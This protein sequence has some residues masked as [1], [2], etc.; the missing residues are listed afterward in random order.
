MRQF[1]D[2][3]LSL[4]GLGDLPRDKELYPTFSPRVRNLLREETQT[5]LERS[6]FE[7]ESSWAEIL[8]AEHT[9][10]NQDLAAYYGFGDV[11]GD[12][13]QRV[14]L[15]R[16][17][18]LGLLTQGAIM[19]AT[20]HSNYTNPVARGAF[21]LKRLLCRD[22]SLPTGETL[23]QIKPPDPYSGRTGRER[24]TAHRAQP[25]CAACHD[26]MDPVG[27][28]FENYDAVG[29]FRAT[30]NDVEIDA[31]GDLVIDGV[32]RHFG[33]AIELARHLG[34][35]TEAMDCFAR[36]W[37]DYAYGQTLGEEDACSVAGATRPFRDSGYVVK[38]LLLGTSQST[39]FMFIPKPQELAP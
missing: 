20:T 21:V 35:S 16:D 22:L 1:F 27:F 6:I 2:K 23:A 17:Q 14:E 5:F 10:L 26:L 39:G 32:E 24:Y 28:S 36:R 18:R 34:G 37:L 31:S 38:E 25:V 29:L 15:P 13:L 30:E 7:D 3:L 8:T 19:A 12:Q 4:A 33:N 11:Q 9:Y